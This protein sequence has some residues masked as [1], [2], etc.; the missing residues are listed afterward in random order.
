MRS[1]SLADYCKWPLLCSPSGPDEFEDDKE[2]A[3]RACQAIQVI[4]AALDAMDGTSGPVMA[5]GASARV[6][7]ITYGWFAAVV[8]NGQLIALSV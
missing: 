2:T 7:P 8:R 4:V 1:V 3:E 5:T 6:F